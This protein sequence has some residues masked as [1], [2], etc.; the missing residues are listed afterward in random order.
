M[1]IRKRNGL[2]AEFKKSNIINAISKA[3]A[4]VRMDDRLTTAEIKEIAKNIEDKCKQATVTITH[5]DIQGMVEKAIMAAGKYD[6]A[7]E[8]I[9]Y[10]W[11][12]A[13]ENKT[14]TTYDKILALLS[15]SNE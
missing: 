9:T 11:M 15:G 1:I 2:E 3:N 5:L 8:Y 7:T 12:K 10:R 14:N 6:V 4:K 13:L